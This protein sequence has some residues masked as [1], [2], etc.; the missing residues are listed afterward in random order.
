MLPALAAS[1]GVKPA[2]GELLPPLGERMTQAGLEAPLALHLKSKGTLAHLAGAGRHLAISA[3]LPCSRSRKLKSPGFE[4]TWNLGQGEGWGERMH[5]VRQ[6]SFEGGSQAAIKRWF[7]L[8]AMADAGDAVEVHS[9]FHAEN[10]VWLISQAF[11]GK[12]RGTCSTASSLLQWGLFS[13]R[14]SSSSLKGT[15]A[16]A[17]NTGPEPGRSIPWWLG[18]PLC[19]QKTQ[20]SKP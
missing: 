6:V 7:P 17:S 19:F 2:E 20:R 12:G 1:V 4:L 11:H 16:P 15:P 10:P 5:R 13:P 14:A 18:H 3:W 9:S 8:V